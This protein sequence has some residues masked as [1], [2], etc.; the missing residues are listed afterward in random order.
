MLNLFN[1]RKKDHDNAAHTCAVCTSKPTNL[2]PVCVTGTAD[3]SLVSV[4]ERCYGALW[5]PELRYTVV[6]T[7]P[8]GWH[9][10]P[11][12]CVAWLDEAIML[13]AAVRAN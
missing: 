5:T 10:Q 3:V 7:D 2:L 8:S 12:I 9:A 1:R 13:A 4:C 6:T 11:V